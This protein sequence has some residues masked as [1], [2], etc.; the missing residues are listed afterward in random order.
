M[1]YVPLKGVYLLVL[2]Y[3]LRNYLINILQN[4][5]KKT[6]SYKHLYR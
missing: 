2:F 4:Q 5:N 1:E 6:A 3:L